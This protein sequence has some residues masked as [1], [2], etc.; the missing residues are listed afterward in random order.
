MQQRT[1]QT[2]KLIGPCGVALAVILFA[3]TDDASAQ[4][5]PRQSRAMQSWAGEKG[6]DVGETI[7]ISYPDKVDLAAF[8][9]YVSQTLKIKII[10]DDQL[11][12]RSVVFRPT[13]VAISRT[14]LLDLLRS[15]LRMNDLA[16]VPGDIEGWLR[17]VPTDDMQRHVQDI[18]AGRL[19]PSADSGQVVSQIVEIHSENMQNVLKHV[20]SFLSSSKASIIEM[21]DRHLVIITDYESAVARAIDIIEL[22]D[23][24]PVPVEVT[25]VPIQHQDASAVAER[26]QQVL[27]DKAKL[28]GLKE[29]PVAIRANLTD[30]EILLIGP[31]E[32]VAE[33]TGLIERFDVPTEERRPTLVYA[34]RHI[35]ADRLQ[36]L[37]ENVLVEEPTGESTLKL[38]LD[39]DTN[40]LYVTA[41]PK[42]HTRIGRLMEAEDIAGVETS[43]PLRFYHPRNRLARD[44]VGILSQLLPSIS[45]SG[46][47][48]ADPQ[49]TEP[50]HV[51]SQRVPANSQ[52]PSSVSAAPEEAAS[53]NPVEPGS[54]PR[55]IEGE[56]F[57]LSHDEHTN[58][59]IAIGPNE[60][61]VR[62]QTLMDELDR[63]QQQVMIEMTLI[64]VTFNDSLSMAVELANE[65]L[66]GSYESIVF[67]SFGLSGIDAETGVRSFQPGGGFN[68][69]LL[70]PHE[71]PLL[72]RAIAAH[73]NSRI[74]ATPKILLSDGTSA[75]IG[76]VEEAP[77][78]S[79]NASDT[80]ATTSFAGFE[81]AGTTMT[82][83][84]HIAQG[85][86][87][88]LDYS[89]SFS[90]FTGSGSVGVPPPRTTN[91]FSGTIEV[92][93]AYTV[94]VGGLVT[95]A[96]SDSVTE[97]PLLGRIPVIGALFQS[98]DRLRT[99]TKVYAFIRP[100]VL[101][102]DAF[103]DLKLIS[104]REM[105]RA[106]LQARD[107]P[108][109]EYLW[110]R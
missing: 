51:D 36:L 110:M 13:E 49:V 109:S 3:A 58:A 31:A 50:A 69:V 82:V 39:A 99:K 103:A 17:I 60:F 67:S 34:P 101:R 32:A 16:L 68:G 11:N 73:G 89:L 97:V 95:E 5:R 35:S 80:V 76:S 21:P 53:A 26:V 14:H 64:A 19:T 57:V 23:V 7:K 8:V 44:L 54:V 12:G 96:E 42:M 85:D 25:A 29:P 62:L 9:D 75:T 28:G 2:A 43:R 66:M 48:D 41:A 63:R 93:D 100:T 18:R 98:S 1:S 4:K 104:R 10:Y 90:N 59:I 91:S 27:T 55:R 83:T 70:G 46:P 40:R 77:F 78:T 107:Y 24:V 38:F 81:S 94:I 84:P 30:A 86:H 15:M 72:V 56:D 102:D 22:L 33:V 71:T 37:I 47:Q 92:P 20:R 65:E 45:E 61:H 88:T 6:L 105:D 74:M 52:G 106:A 108:E 87:I 79:I